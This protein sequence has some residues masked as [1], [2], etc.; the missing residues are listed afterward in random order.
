MRITDTPER[1]SPQA[2]ALLEMAAAGHLLGEPEQ[3]SLEQYVRYAYGALT[4]SEACELEQ[5]LQ[6][7]PAHVETLARVYRV[8][9][10]L[11]TTPLYN[12]IQSDQDSLH[13]QVQVIWT[14][15]LQDSESQT[16]QDST[17]LAL[18]ALTLSGKDAM[19]SVRKFL[20]DLLDPGL[21]PQR[22][23][24]AGSLRTSQLGPLLE[25]MEVEVSLDAQIEPDGSLLLTASIPSEGIL[26]P[27][28]VCVGF[29]LNRQWVRLGNAPVLEGSCTLLIPGFGDLIG[30][31]AGPLPPDLFALRPDV[32]PSVCGTG[33][34]VVQAGNMPFAEVEVP[35]TSASG[36][37]SL[38]LRLLPESAE[39]RQAKELEVWFGTGGQ[40]WQLV[41]R[42][43]IPPLSVGT[44]SISFPSPTR[45]TA[46]STFSG[47]LKLALKS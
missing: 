44:M 1:F 41:G 19:R 8:A 9:E 29:E 33:N 17:L 11:R 4:E 45:T 16:A 12:S 5:T 35:P 36:S 31:S 18:A 10:E 22:V 46:S 6:T 30:L 39:L 37:I 7:Y 20:M 3:P 42:W 32:W 13:Q 21:A 47:I 28:N 38:N 14:R 40:V 15:L 23:A 25:N 24:F 34:F 2:V 27:T 26:K 43:P